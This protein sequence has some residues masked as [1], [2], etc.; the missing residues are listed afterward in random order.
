MRTRALYGD[1]L[2]EIRTEVCG[3]CPERVPGRP[4]LG[5]RCRRCGVELH[6]AELVES[7]HEAGSAVVEY[8]PPP[9]RRTACALCACLGSAVC[10]CPVAALIH[11]VVRAVRAVDEQRSQTAVL[12]RRLGP[13][14]RDQAPAAALIRSY[15]AATG[16]CVCCD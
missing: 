7:L 8:G 5:A 12:R 13:S 16:T 1:Y 2:A 9:D 11:R 4:P 6:L 10:P 14:R 3:H 15:E